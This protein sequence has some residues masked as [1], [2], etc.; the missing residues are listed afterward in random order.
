MVSTSSD[1]RQLQVALVGYGLAGRFFH[2]PLISAEPRMT[3]A[4]IVT[5]DA[6]RGA[7]AQQEYPHAEVVADLRSV[8]QTTSA[9]D[10]VVVAS[11]NVAHVPQAL[12][13]L[14]HG[15]HVVV[16][17]PV[18]ESTT[19]ALELA[20]AAEAA[21]RQLHVFQN[22]RWDSDFLTLRRLAPQVGDIHRLESRIERWRPDLRGVWRE[23]VR[24]ED[25]GGLRLDLGAHLVDQALQLLGPARAVSAHVRSLRAHDAA[26]DDVLIT[27]QHRS[28]ALSLLTA[29][30]VAAVPGPRFRLLGTDG[31]VLIDH[32]DGQE[33]ALRQGTRPDAPDWGVE[34]IEHAAV[35]VAR[36]GS[37][38]REALDAGAWPEYYRR[39]S[40]SVND[41]APPPVPFADV[42]AAMRVLDAARV[43]SGELI[44]LP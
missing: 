14:A 1:S 6:Q 27:I 24:P 32:A 12:E 23:S 30:A 41:G 42:I 8:W 22:R 33:D 34:P 20:A 16:D 18:A 25:G 37:T 2:A 10:L 19:I 21:N 3:L 28:G 29:S 40:A 9:I 36:D 38:T 39:V 31:G 4:A 5:S 15:C 35:V 11:A 26:D 43:S 44:D 17:K 13:A 7:Q